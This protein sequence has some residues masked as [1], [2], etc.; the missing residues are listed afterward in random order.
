M[1]YFSS[2]QLSAANF[3][4]RA[5]FLEIRPHSE[6]YFFSDKMYKHAVKPNLSCIFALKYKNN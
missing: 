6:W 2:N 3:Q 4:D 1:K 5:V